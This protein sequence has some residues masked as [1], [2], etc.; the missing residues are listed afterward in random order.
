MYVHVCIGNS[1]LH[2]ERKLEYDLKLQGFLHNKWL[3][4]LKNVT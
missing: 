2:P 3:Q 1:S 4:L